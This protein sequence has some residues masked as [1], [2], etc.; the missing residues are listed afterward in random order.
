MSHVTPSQPSITDLLARFL[1]Q[2]SQAQA[3]GFS[4]DTRGEVTPYEAG[5]VQPIDAQLAWEQAVVAA[6]YYEPEALATVKWAPPPHWVSIVAAHE[7]AVALAFCLGNFPQLVR[8][9][10]LILQKADL[11]QLQPG[12]GRPMPVPGLVEW[13]QDVA[14]KRQYPQMLLAV[15][16]LRLSKNFEQAAAFVEANDALIPEEWRTAWTNE[17]AGLS[18]HQGQTDTAR[19]LWDTMQANVPVLFNRGM[20]DL[21]LG[22]TA[23][24]SAALNLVVSKLPEPSPWHHLARLYLTLGQAK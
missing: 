13:A 4:C 18:W 2:R 15:G 9:F 3:D 12:G 14:A 8:N 5:P 17:K 24:A 10:H 6:A 22:R 19:A 11:T 1:N 20:A 23:Q 16:A 21:F 7:P